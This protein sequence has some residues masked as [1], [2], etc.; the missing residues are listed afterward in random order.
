MENPSTPNRSFA[1]PCETTERRIQFSATNK[2][3]KNRIKLDY[4]YKKKKKHF[5][6][7]VERQRGG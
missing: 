2:E 4:R 1:P 5:Y 3:N 7:A 6:S